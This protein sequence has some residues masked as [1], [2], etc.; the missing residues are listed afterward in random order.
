MNSTREKP[1]LYNETDPKQVIDIAKAV[2]I[3][4]T[5]TLDTGSKLTVEAL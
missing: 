3:D 2:N 5:A 4:F 1:P